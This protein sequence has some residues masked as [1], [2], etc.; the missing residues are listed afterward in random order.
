MDKR[1]A[2]GDSRIARA[3]SRLKDFSL[4]KVGKLIVAVA[5]ILHLVMSQVHVSGLLKLEDQIC[6]FVMFLSVL[7]GLV[8]LFQSTRAKY[9]DVREFI[10]QAFFLVVTICCT[11]YLG[12][13]YWSALNFQASLRDAA[14]V[15]KAFSLTV[16]MCVAYITALVAFSLDYAVRGRKCVRGKCVDA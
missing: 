6:G 1:I 13:I 8:C 4:L 16:G 9:N 15:V 14:S 10:P 11:A 2:V 5:S 12:R 3:K 7:F